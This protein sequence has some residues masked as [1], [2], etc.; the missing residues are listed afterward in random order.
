M[1]GQPKIGQKGINLLS[2]VLACIAI[3]LDFVGHDLYLLFKPLTTILIVSLLFF[4]SKTGHSKFKLIM[5]IA[6]GFCLLGDILL[7]NPAYFVFG[8]VAFLL[9]HLLF[10][11]A[12][13]QHKGFRFHWLSFV[14]LYGIGGATF[15]WLKPDLG[16]FMIP[17]LVYVLVITSMA[18]QGIGM[19]VRD[20]GRAYAWI[21]LAVL[22]FML[23]DTLLAINKFK[24]PF[25]YASVLILATYWLSIALL[26]NATFKI[27]F[28]D[29]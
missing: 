2:V 23:S 14:L 15:F 3:Y 8:L 27:E 29:K 17:V 10:I 28:N 26:A 7:L 22:F 13:I 5:V 12:F 19:Y 6:F 25:N 1:V 24:A 21:A 16:D 20:K 4:T 18:W 11:V 9:A